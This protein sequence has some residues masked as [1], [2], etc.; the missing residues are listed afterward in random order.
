M[1]KTTYPGE[2]RAKQA[3]LAVLYSYLSDVIKR[4]KHKSLMLSGMT[5]GTEIRLIKSLLGNEVHAVDLDPA[6]CEAAMKAGADHVYC[7]DITDWNRWG[8]LHR[9][10]V[11]T[12][13]VDMCQ[14]YGGA[15]GAVSGFCP[16]ST[17]EAI[18][19]AAMRSWY[20][21]VFFPYG[22]DNTANINEM[23]KRNPLSD[24]LFEYLP[25]TVAARTAAM[26]TSKNLG[27]VQGCASGWLPSRVFRYVGNK[28]PILGAVMT[29]DMYTKHESDV[30]YF[31]D[32][33]NK[34][35][36]CVVSWFAVKHGVDTA[37]YVFGKTTKQ[38]IAHKAVASRGQRDVLGRSDEPIR[39]MRD[40]RDGDRARV[41]R[42]FE[43]VNAAMMR[44]RLGEG[45]AVDT[46]E[47]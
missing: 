4:D 24:V 11:Q 42:V 17:T 36:S 37:A 1:R 15:A 18:R 12:S 32:L 27:V 40:I 10:D 43:S 38:I 30:P 26:M 14:P 6:C 21:C 29:N 9:L 46:D 28:M 8:K 34:D 19:I 23:A 33:R 2:T 44:R 35:Y 47:T 39:V 45:R 3:V 16:S 7:C 13:D 5:P 31:V 20:A 22:R 25:S 41:R